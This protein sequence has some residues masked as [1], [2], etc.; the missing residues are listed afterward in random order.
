LPRTAIDIMNRLR[1]LRAERRL[2][3]VDTA[4]SAGIGP[5]RYW[6]IE[7]DYT[8]PTDVEREALTRVFGVSTDEIFPSP[9]STTA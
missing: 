6:K 8:K 7:N 4:L 3:Q 2:S 1:V 5:T 9:D